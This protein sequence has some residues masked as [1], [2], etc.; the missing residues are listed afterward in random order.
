MEIVSDQALMDLG[1]EQQGKIVSVPGFGYFPQEVAELLDNLTQVD[2][3]IM[4]FDIKWILKQA[5]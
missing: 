4:N 2:I 5:L 1:W 3:T